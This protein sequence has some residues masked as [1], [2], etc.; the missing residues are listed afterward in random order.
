MATKQSFGSKMPVKVSGSALKAIDA[1]RDASSKKI[2]TVQTGIPDDFIDAGNKLDKLQ[3]EIASKI[4]ATYN[5]FVGLGSDYNAQE[6]NQILM[7]SKKTTV[8]TATSRKKQLE[9]FK[10]S[11]S[12]NGVAEM[13]VQ[14]RQTYKASLYQSYD[15]AL[16]IIPKMK[17]ALST[18]ADSIISPDDFTKRSLSV[19]FNETNLE[20]DKIAETKEKIKAVIEKFDIEKNLKRDITD[21]LAKGEK[22]FAVLSLNSEVKRMLK[23][24]ADNK[25]EGY[26]TLEGTAFSLNEHVSTVEESHMIGDGMR[27]FH[28]E[29]VFDDVPTRQKFVSDLDQFMKENMVIGNSTHFLHEHQK[30]N[31]EMAAVNSFNVP[32]GQVVG[33]KGATAKSTEDASIDGL[34]IAS[35]SAVCR[36]LASDRCVKLEYD[37]RVYGYIYIDSIAIDEKQAANNANQTAAAG[38]GGAAPGVNGVTSAVQGVLYSSNDIGVG[39]GGQK[40]IG[41]TNDPKLMF[42]ANVFANRLSKK[43][44]ISM[45]RKSEQ[46]KYVIYHS[47]ITKRITKDEK[48]RVLFFS[49]DEVV[50]IDRKESIFDNVLFFVKM[51]IATL[52]TI[53]M[54]NIIRGADK[55]AYYIDVGLENDA[56]NAINATIRDIKAKDISNVHNMDMSS[57]MGAVSEFNDY[58]IPTIDGEKPISMETIKLT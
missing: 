19:S 3:S 14:Q 4:S 28:E 55:R 47:L 42:I 10:K 20:A 17:L 33:A 31:E 51:Y 43:E 34:R 16:S 22:F 44:N 52:I 9:D 45:I 7:L 12:N 2:Q 40:A 5:N 25:N 32:V 27:I 58:Y 53:L 46:L 6:V 1:L 36:V 24:N 39:V 30:I 29:K 37:G 15:L 18:I 50:H 8:N 54:Q 57:I 48:M 26:R 21:T 11:V 41:P 38:S 13:L 35:D 49:A 56:A 23:E